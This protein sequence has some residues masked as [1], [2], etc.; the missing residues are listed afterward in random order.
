MTHHFTIPSCNCNIFQQEE[1]AVFCYK[2]GPV[3]GGE[4]PP[5]YTVDILFQNWEP[6]WYL[7][8]R[9]QWCC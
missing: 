5:G 1:Q 6:Y 9:G 7:L 2:Q 3:T 4:C 8:D